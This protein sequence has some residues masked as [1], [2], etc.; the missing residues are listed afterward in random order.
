[1]MSRHRPGDASSPRGDITLLPSAT[2][3]S[4]T[5]LAQSYQALATGGRIQNAIQGVRSELADLDRM[6]NATLSHLDNLIAKAKLGNMKRTASEDT[7]QA[8]PDSET[9]D[10]DLTRC[11]S[12]SDVSHL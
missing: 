11:R 5:H 1:M 12:C 9:L 2:N 3:S 6:Q 8:R 4:S 10:R 7:P